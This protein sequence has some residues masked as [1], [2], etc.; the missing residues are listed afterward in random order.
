MSIVEKLHATIQTLVDKHHPNRLLDEPTTH[1]DQ[2]DLCSHHFGVNGLINS[3]N[4]CYMNSTLQCILHTYDVVGFFSDKNIQKFINPDKPHTRLLVSFINILYTYW[5]QSNE[6]LDPF[7]FRQLLGLFNQQFRNHHQQDAHEFLNYILDTFHECTKYT[8]PE[9]ILDTYDKNYESQLNKIPTFRTKELEKII[10]I[11]YGFSI[12]NHIFAINEIQQLRCDSSNCNHSSFQIT[13]SYSLI[14]ELTKPKK[15]IQ[16]GKIIHTTTLYTCLNTYFSP[17]R[18][19]EWICSKCKKSGGSKI[20]RMIN[21][22]TTLIITL[23]RFVVNQ[24][25]ARK[26]NESIHYPEYLDMT[27][28]IYTGSSSDTSDDGSIDSGHYRLNSVVCQIGS[29]NGGHYYSYARHLNNQWF[30]FN[31]RQVMPVNISEVLNDN[32]NAYILFYT[33]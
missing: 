29:M 28:Y 10:N 17:C 5:K 2:I 26:N 21:T 31:D 6:S 16:H 14:L 1:D 19:D 25:I 9:R 30:S 32:N 18:M 24:G 20:L 8:Y 13:H 4:S 11:R 23:N 22:P 7:E 3:A 15:L 33:R 12:I 27:P